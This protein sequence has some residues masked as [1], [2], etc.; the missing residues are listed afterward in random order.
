MKQH[1]WLLLVAALAIVGLAP[2]R[3]TVAQA[4]AP[5]Q[6]GPPPVPKTIDFGSFFPG[7]GRFVSTVDNFDGLVAVANI[8][9]TGKDNNGNPVEFEVDVRSLQGVYA[10]AAGFQQRGTFVFT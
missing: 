5:V 1:R 4:Q 8:Q 9:G 6:G 7:V 3:P 2:P 10:Q